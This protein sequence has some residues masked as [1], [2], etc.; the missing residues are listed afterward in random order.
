MAKTNLGKVGLTPKKA[1][2]ADTTY[3][4]LDFVTAGDSS[5]VSLQDNN[6]GHPVTDEVWWQVLA[7]GAA[8]TEAAT[9]ALDAAAKALEAAAA[10]APV[11]VNVEGAAAAIDVQPNHIYK[12]G[13]LTSL[14]IRSVAD[15]PQIAE[16]IFTSGA[17]ATELT[18]PNTLAD[19][20][21][22]WKIP[23]ANKT[24]KIFFQSNTATISY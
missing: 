2:S 6:L 12:C 4:R 19:N 15:S 22:G 7:S 9:A 23:Q 17:T 16:V 13:E 8:S 1:Y 11:V 18:M 5:Y 3:E 14:N 21:T 20:V 24:Y 10:A